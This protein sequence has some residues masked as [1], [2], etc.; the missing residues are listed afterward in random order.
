M[1]LRRLVERRRPQHSHCR[2]PNVQPVKVRR[3]GRYD[4]NDIF[5]DLLT[6][7]ELEKN[8]GLQSLR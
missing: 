6:K 8:V 1:T 7:K 5:A 4:T 3:L 2:R